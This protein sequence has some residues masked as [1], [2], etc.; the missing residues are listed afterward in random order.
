M[1]RAGIRWVLIGI[2]VLAGAGE[3]FARWRMGLGNPP[4]NMAHPRIEYLLRP[5]QDLPYFGHRF[6]VNA[7]GMRSRPFSARKANGELR[8]L[9]FGDSVVNA[10]NLTNQEELATER[11]RQSLER[12]RRIPVTVGNV[13]AGSWG[14]GNWLAYAREYGF[15]DADAVVL[16]ISSHDYA[17]NPSFKP[18]NTRAFPTQRPVS[19]LVEAL[20]HYVHRFV[21][22]LRSGSR[23]GAAPVA[24]SIE[25]EVEKGL[26]D[27]AAFLQL[28]R[29]Q[30]KTVLVVQHL[31]KSELLEG[32]FEPGYRRIQEVC[33]AAGVQTIS[34]EPYFRQAWQRGVD[35]YWDHI[36]P[37]AA[38]QQ[39]IAEAVLAHLPQ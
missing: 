34:L 29:W 7:Y 3:W 1:R 30:V 20:R 6:V 16:V 9:V 36:H 15:F 27:L 12:T 35:P 23:D 24:A 38:G 8:V 39:L 26:S 17:D 14:P 10:G 37:N 11:I 32:S 4:L 31:E 2:A 22:S 33:G 13:S 21:R 5:N 28:A 18:L 19:A 25:A